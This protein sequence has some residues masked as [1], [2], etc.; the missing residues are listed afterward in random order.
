MLIVII[1]NNVITEN[2]PS[3]KWPKLKPRTAK[4]SENSLVWPNESAIK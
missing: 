1:A 3:V 2:N 4:I